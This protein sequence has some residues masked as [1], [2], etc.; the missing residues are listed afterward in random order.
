MRAIQVLVVFFLCHSSALSQVLTVTGKD[1][2]EPIDLAT[3]MS[4]NGQQFATTN[5]QGQ[6]DISNFKDAPHIE[7]RKLGY[8]TVVKSYA[9]LQADGLQVQLQGTNIQLDAVVVAATRWNQETRD[10][11]SK[12]TTISANEVAMQNPQTA[13]DV[14]SVSGKVFVQKS[15][16][17]GGSPMIRGFATNRLLYSV[18]GVR[19][20]TAIFRSGNIQNVISIDPFALQSTEVLFGAGSVIYGSD[21]IGGVMSFRTLTPELSLGK[22]P[23]ING[24]AVTRYAS[25]NNEFTG[26]VDVAV[27]W[28][29]F[30]LLSSASYNRYGHLKMGTY[31][32]DEYL[33]H[34]YVQRM[35]STDVVVSNNNPRMQH[36][37]G[38]TQMNLMQKLRY[39]PN[40]KWDFQYGFHWSET[41]AYARYDRHIRTRNGEPRYGEWDYG[42]QKWMMNLLEFTHSVTQGVYDQMHVRLAQQFFA[43]SRIS[44][45]FNLHQ[46]EIKIENVYAYSGNLDFVKAIGSKNKLYYGFE[47]IWNDVIS[48]GIVENIA[49]GVRFEG[50]TRY[51]ASNWSSYGVYISNQYRVHPKATIQAGLRYNHFL[52][53]AV[54]DTTFYPFPF[55]QAS[56]NNG[57]LTGSLGVVYR[58]H[59]TWVLSG[60]FGTAFRAPN[61]D[62]VGKVFDSEPGTVV[63]PN[64]ALRAEYAYNVEGSVAKV[65]SQWLKLDLTGFYTLLTNALVRRNFMLNNQDSLMYD[66]QMSQ[67][68]AMQN[69]SIAYVYGLQA[70]AEVK[71]PKGFGFSTHFNWQIGKEELTD[72]TTSPSRHAA[73][74]FGVSSINYRYKTLRLQLNARYSGA[75]KNENLP[76]EE[77][78]KDYIYASNKN[79]LPWSPGWYTINFKASYQFLHNFT[80]STGIENL[81]DQR[82][83]PYSS[84]IVAPGR[85]FVLAVKAT[86]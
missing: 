59:K 36:P 60:Q 65:F 33:R 63:V 41:S 53:N 7:I 57:A 46:R 50:P 9:Q 12:I 76:L 70:G 37:S 69:T 17:G 56:L 71:L 34:Y 15:Q 78:G 13:A 81:T 2:G 32:P 79:G 77:Q 44:R 28:K 23:S 1:D 30:A 45:G 16:Q 6:V 3:L 67:V 22:K 47:V 21:A 64:P 51:P 48:T 82:Y 54:F 66:G 5:A 73:P 39:T 18:D 83:R 20:N 25:A 43:E 68:Q 31:G 75:V 10:V 80:V 11:P 49:T 35:D 14:L 38:Y 26:H 85:N 61:V 29:K 86:F 27:G 72:G 84:G 4:A 52:L 55:T 62:D 42:P 24:K 58:P 40:K 8:Q 74:W 19:M